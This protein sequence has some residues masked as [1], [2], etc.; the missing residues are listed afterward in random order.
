M[1]FYW[2]CDAFHSFVVTFRI[3]E[4][5][6]RIKIFM[7]VYQNIYLHSKQRYTWTLIKLSAWRNIT[8]N[9]RFIGICQPAVSISST[10]FLRNPCTT[11]YSYMMLTNFMGSSLMSDIFFTIIII[12]S[13][14]L[15]KIVCLFLFKVYLN[16]Y[17]IKLLTM[18]LT[19]AHNATISIYISLVSNI[20]AY[21][22][23]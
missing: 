14:T 10:H 23:V 6:L 5:Y 21:T 19:G 11:R 22:A 13:S 1:Q 7:M 20:Y 17:L 8:H 15:L 12:V 2:Q 3:S 16:N 9:S 18:F 4:Y